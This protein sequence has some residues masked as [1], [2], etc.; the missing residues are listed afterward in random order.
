MSAEEAYL[1]W[2]WVGAFWVRAGREIIIEPSTGVEERAIRLPLLG[3]VLGA[4]LQQRGYLALH[5][6][7]VALN[8]S[9]VAFLGRKGAGK[10][11]MAAAL[12]ARGH[13][14]VADDLVALYVNGSENPMALPGFPQLKLWPEAAA[15]SLGEDAETL[16]RLNADYEK[17]GRTTADRFSPSALPLRRMYL[18]AQSS[19]PGIEPLPPQE[20]IINLIGQSYAARVFGKSLRGAAAAATL[21]Q[22]THLARRVPFAW[23]KRRASLEA[24]PEVARMV[25]QD[26]CQ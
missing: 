6:S 1:L 2:D 8:G 13:H 21:L 15:A 23:L 22:C 12:Y 20:A 19:D 10:S 7:A 25:E 9:V 5:A 24:L 26:L 14:L 11:T 3:M 16:P 18:L 17:R 4:L